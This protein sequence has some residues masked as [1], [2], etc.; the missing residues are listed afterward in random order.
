MGMK[1]HN[2]E[3]E[4]FERMEAYVLGTMPTLEREHYEKRLRADA[5]LRAE[6]E[7]QQEHIHAV[8]LGGV[9]RTLR[10]LARVQRATP[11]TSRRWVSYLKVAAVVTLVLAS[12]IWWLSR[13]TTGEQL[14]AEHFRPDPG[15]P[16]AMDASED[17]AFDDAMVDYK[18]QAFAAAREKWSSQL[19]DRPG[20][21]TLRYYTAM[22]ALGAGDIPGAV[23]LLEK[24]SADTASPFADKAAWYL[25]LAYTHAGDTAHARTVPFDPASPFA[26]RAA[27]IQHALR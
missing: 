16:V 19:K 22:A 21:D 10:E 3:Q 8:E 20:S 13:P 17:P 2:L 25:F 4:E 27:T 11:V 5:A 7:Q 14:F 12:A 15:L 23:P 9:Q 26:A 6:L 24:A 18:M 1:N